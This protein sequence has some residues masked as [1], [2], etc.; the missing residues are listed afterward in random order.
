MRVFMRESDVECMFVKNAPCADLES[1]GSMCLLIRF[2]P[3][4]YTAQGD[5][6]EGHNRNVTFHKITQGRAVSFSCTGKAFSTKLHIFLVRL[7]N[8]TKKL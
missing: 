8:L 7:Y 3:A 4:F 6:T 1:R 2:S 5:T